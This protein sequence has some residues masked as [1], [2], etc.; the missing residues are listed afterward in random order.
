VL[1]T[2]FRVP[3]EDVQVF[4]VEILTF[5]TL[6][7]PGESLDAVP[8]DPTD[9][10]ILECAVAA[11]SEVIV[12]GDQGGQASRALDAAVVPPVP[13]ERGPVAAQRARVQPRQPGR[14]LL[15]PKRVDSWSLTSL[16]QR[17]VKTGGRLVKHSRYY[18]LLLAESHLT[19]RLFGSMLQRIWALP[20]P[21]G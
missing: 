13:G 16:Q 19:R 14:R 17:L 12:S 21:T 2:K 18:W 3:A 20:L 4:R 1:A 15:L 10:R 7:T 9:N 6:V 11:G 5:A 8:A